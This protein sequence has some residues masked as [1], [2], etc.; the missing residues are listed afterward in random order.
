MTTG[1]GDERPRRD[2]DGISDETVAAKT[3]RRWDEWRALLDAEGAA[4]MTHAEIARHLAG[5]HALGAWWSQMVTVAYERATGRRQVHEKAEGFS[6][7]VSRTLPFSAA[8]LF[9]AWADAARRARWLPDPY[10]EVRG[11]RPDRTLRLAWVDGSSRVVVAF[12]AKGEGRC[13]VVV[14]HERLP[15][16]EAVAR[17]KAYWAAAL[18][19]LRAVL[20]A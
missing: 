6:A 15:D 16:A 20:Q 7:G 18:A 19:R 5:R 8:T 10:L 3:G 14:Q 12:N 4:A 11:A 2:S 9:A 17:M 1:S 13:Q